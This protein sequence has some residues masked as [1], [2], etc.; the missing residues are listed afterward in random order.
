MPR[1]AL[2]LTLLL[3]AACESPPPPTHP[4]MLQKGEYRNLSTVPGRPTVTVPIYE[5]MAL[6]EELK[7]ENKS[8]ND[9]QLWHGFAP[10]TPQLP[11]KPPAVPAEI[12]E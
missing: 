7:A 3:L 11:D 4:E 2:F 8:A 1:I 9:A 5:R 10:D 12:P 6:E